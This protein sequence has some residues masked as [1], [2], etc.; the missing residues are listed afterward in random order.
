VRFKIDNEIR[1]DLLICELLVVSYYA[2]R[3]LYLSVKDKEACIPIACFQE[4]F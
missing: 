3:S 4:D 1:T 2:N